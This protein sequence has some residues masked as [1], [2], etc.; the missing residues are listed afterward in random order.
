MS[1]EGKNGFEDGGRW[2]LRQVGTSAGLCLR[3]FQR[4]LFS[5]SKL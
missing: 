5:E 2:W 1:L 4:L 3:H